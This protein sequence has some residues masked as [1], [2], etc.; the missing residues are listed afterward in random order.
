MSAS[1]GKKEEADQKDAK[2]LL[3]SAMCKASKM[4]RPYFSKSAKRLLQ[5]YYAYIR[6][7]RDFGEIISSKTVPVDTFQ[8][9]L[10]LSTASAK[11][12]LSPVIRSVPDVTLAIKL[13]EETLFERVNVLS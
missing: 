11:L 8:T 1:A 3:R 13:T 12:T 2:A 7:P 10:R 5:G 6:N 9:L 4:K